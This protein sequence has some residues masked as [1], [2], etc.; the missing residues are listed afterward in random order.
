MAV[1]LEGNI[2]INAQTGQGFDTVMSQL[3]RMRSAADML[4]APIREWEKESVEIYKDYETNMLKARA[5]MS[6]QYDS[7]N[8]LNNVMETLEKQVQEWAVNSVFHVS[9]FSEAVNNASHAGWNLEQQL[10]G[11]P[12]AMLL[13]Q[14]GNM[15]LADGLSYLARALNV[16]GTDFEDSGVLVDQWVKASHLANL[17]IEDLGQSLERMGVTAQFTE[18][19]AELFTMLDTLAETGVV[20]AQAGTLLRGTMLRLIAPTKKATEA[21]AGLEV[22]EE[23]LSDLAGDSAA[24]EKANKEL[25]KVGFSAYDTAGQLKPMMRIY[26]DLYEALVSIAGGEEDLLKNQ[27]V[28][29]ILSALFPTRTISG[30]LAFLQGVKGGWKDLYDEILDSE[31]AAESDSETVMSGLMGAQERFLSKWDL[32]QLFPFCPPNT[33]IPVVIISPN[34]SRN[35]SQRIEKN[36]SVFFLT[37][38]CAS[39]I[40]VSPVFLPPLA[41]ARYMAT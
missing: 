22:T 8:E 17:T 39:S 19:T 24:L 32:L 41:S 36:P 25:E 40:S 33:L 29:E 30:A 35:P 14:A 34:V 12:R 16:T 38:L 10:Q 2:I 3:N 11:I 37:V 1:N 26:D 20:G 5:A 21:M 6:D 27:T 23:E 28:D 9:D 4:G 31:G 13:A 18:N 7:Y 15:D